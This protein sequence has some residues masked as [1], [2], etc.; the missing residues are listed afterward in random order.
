MCVQK[1]PYICYYLLQYGCQIFSSCS[2]S[3]CLFMHFAFMSV[4]D[5]FLM[6]YMSRSQ[7]THA[8][9]KH[10]YFLRTWMAIAAA[11]PI[12]IIYIKFEISFSNFFPLCNYVS[13]WCEVKLHTLILKAFFFLNPSELYCSFS[14]VKRTWIYCPRGKKKTLTVM[15]YSVKKQWL[16]S[17]PI[18]S[19]NSSLFHELK[20]FHGSMFLAPIDVLMHFLQSR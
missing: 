11:L 7:C 4:S 8:S 3:S 2:R 13:S 12:T 16:V 14:V 17:Q 18:C 6:A 19:S 9:S 1:G 10:A 15:C 5:G 20:D